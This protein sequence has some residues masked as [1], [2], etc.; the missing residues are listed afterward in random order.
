[1]V[2]LLKNLTGKYLQVDFLISFKYSHK[3]AQIERES[4]V[5]DMHAHLR[6]RVPYHTGIAKESGIDLVVA[7]P[8]TDP[9]LDTPE[10]VKEYVAQ[11]SAC[12]VLPMGA[13]TY[14]RAGK[15]MVDLDA[16]RPYVVGFTDD[17][18]CLKDLGILR[19]ILQAGVWVMLHCGVEKG[20]LH[21]SRS[22]DEP[23]WIGRYLKIHGDAGGRI[24]FQHVSR[25]ES[26]N[27]V[28]DGKASLTGDN[29]IMAETCPHYL[30]WTKNT[31]RVPVNPPIG[32][33][34]DREAVR[35][36]LSDGT[37]D[38]IASD[39]APEPR[40]KG[41]GIADFEGFIPS[42]RRLVDEGVL[43]DDQ[44]IEKIYRNPRKVIESAGFALGL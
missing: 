17:G 44:L 27:L 8:N 22:T 14:G 25:K 42:C 24:Y 5:I 10:R 11:E 40:P 21:E 39:Y 28:R 20:G 13:I 7:M 18:N 3:I 31:M 16:M 2:S 12:T 23:R 30:K 6:D 15:K 37:I 36:G 4:P 35:E 43:T 38:I 19:D 9:C 26:V 1:M 34:R 29:K 32:S 33:A 41:T